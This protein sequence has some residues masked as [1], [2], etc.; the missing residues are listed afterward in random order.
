MERTKVYP[1]LAVALAL[2]YVCARI[3]IAL[4]S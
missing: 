2:A 3:V 4:P 1:A